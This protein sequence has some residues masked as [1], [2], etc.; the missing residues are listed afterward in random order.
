MVAYTYVPVIP[1]V[2][3]GMIY[4]NGVPMG[5]YGSAAAVDKLN[6]GLYGWDVTAGGS[7]NHPVHEWPPVTVAVDAIP[8]LP[9]SE[10]TNTVYVPWD[11]ATMNLHT[12]AESFYFEPTTTINA[13]LVTPSA[14]PYD[15]SNSVDK[16]SY[17]AAPIAYMTQHGGNRWTPKY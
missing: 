17:K 8:A 1:D 3:F 7:L 6:E 13:T 16:A 5:Q 9:P 11:D 10:V 12:V 14:F 4:Y 15:V 2:D